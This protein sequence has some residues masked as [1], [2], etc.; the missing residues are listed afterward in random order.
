L[1][2]EGCQAEGLAQELVANQVH[3][4]FRKLRFF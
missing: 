4:F 3:F 1:R 2:R